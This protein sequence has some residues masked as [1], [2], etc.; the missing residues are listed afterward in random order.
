MRVRRR[1]DTGAAVA[2]FALVSV[3][4]VFLFLGVVQLGTALF[5]RN[6]LVACAAEGARYGANAD[7]DEVD[8]VT[9]A[10]ALIASSLP[11][12][13]AAPGNVTAGYESVGGSPTLYVEVRADLPLLGWL[14]ADGLLIVRA[15]ALEEGGG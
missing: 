4:L 11:D 5:V 3:L 2:E 10:S 6:T 1:N 9:R 7:R 14:D 13:Y 12:S 15:H 8:A